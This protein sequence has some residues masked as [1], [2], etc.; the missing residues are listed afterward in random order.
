MCPGGY[1]GHNCSELC[2]AGSYGLKCAQI[3]EC[4]PCHHIY[5]CLSKTGTEG[6]KICLLPNITVK[7]VHFFY[8][9]KTICIFFKFW[10]RLTLVCVPFEKKMFQCKHQHL[11]LYFHWKK[12]EFKL[13][14]TNNIS[15]SRK[16]RHQSLMTYIIMLTLLIHI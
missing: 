13:I 8:L 14:H 1:F 12:T 4:F 6:N 10:P 11:T 9:S 16:N 5:G 7:H 15:E 3:C 2:Q